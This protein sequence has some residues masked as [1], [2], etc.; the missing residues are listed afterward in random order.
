MCALLIIE[1]IKY[2]IVQSDI[3]DESLMN[4][5]TFYK[6]IDKR[7]RLRK[8]THWKREWYWVVLMKS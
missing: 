3:H 5:R 7:R 8:W 1:G 4:A 6:G 2:R